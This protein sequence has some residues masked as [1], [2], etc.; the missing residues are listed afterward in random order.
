MWRQLIQQYVQKSKMTSLP[1]N[2][3]N[4]IGR[5]TLIHSALSGNSG[6]FT[7]PEKD[8]GI[9][10]R[11]VLYLWCVSIHYLGGASSKANVANLMKMAPTGSPSGAFATKTA[12]KCFFPGTAGSSNRTLLLV[13]FP[14][15]IPMVRS[16]VPS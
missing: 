13:L 7:C 14:V 5:V 8:S 6:A 2:S 12:I 4:V 1:R 10:L 3:L 16:M 9:R 11:S 15:I